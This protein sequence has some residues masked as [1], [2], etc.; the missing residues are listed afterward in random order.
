MSLTFR[1]SGQSWIIW[2]LYWAI[3][4]PLGDSIYLR[5]SQE[6]TWNS[7]L[8]AWAKRMLAQS[9]RSTSWDMGFVLGN[10][11]RVNE[12][13]IQVDDDYDIN[14]IHKNVIHKLL[15]SCW[16]ISKP[17]R[18]YQPLEGTITGSECSLPFISSRNPDK[19]IHMPEVDFGVDSCF[20]GCVQ[21]VGNERKWISVLLG[22]SV[23]ASE[24]DAKSERAVFFLDEKDRSSMGRAGGTD[25]PCGK[26]LINE[27]TKSR[28]FFLGQG[29]D[30]TIGR[31]GA[32]VQ[33]DLEIVWSMV[34]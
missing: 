18:H 23:E 22:N 26:V 17:F 33:G 28:K 9:S 11:V 24:V 15:K 8:S 4:R 34:G 27:L 29:I 13:V 31:S 10:V 5:Y 12:G 14:H 25:E 3:V 32:L 7:H 20:S 30:W 16:C 1:G 2:T 6:V 21:E 19:M